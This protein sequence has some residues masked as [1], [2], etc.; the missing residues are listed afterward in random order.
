[1]EI[2]SPLQVTCKFI[3]FD[4]VFAL[5][6]SAI[7]LYVL[8]CAE[9]DFSV[10]YWSSVMTMDESIL[11]VNKPF[12]GDFRCQSFGMALEILDPVQF[13]VSRR[14]HSLRHQ[15]CPCSNLFPRSHCT[16]NLVSK[17]VQFVISGEIDR[18]VLS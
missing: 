9:I 13:T 8:W 14:L 18:P 5:P 6:P 1:M 11:F 2:E 17:S 7:F 12:V 10:L 3:S 16:W 15:D 4:A